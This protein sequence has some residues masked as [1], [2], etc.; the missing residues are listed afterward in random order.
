MKKL[1]F[2]LM[3]FVMA[4]SGC[5]ATKRSDV[6]QADSEMRIAQLERKVYEKDQQIEELQDQVQTLSSDKQRSSK[7]AAPRQETMKPAM[8]VV[9]NQSSQEQL[10]EQQKLLI[11]VD[12]SPQD[13]QTALKNAGY[14]DGNIDGKIGPRSQKAIMDFQADHN[15]KSDGIIG[16]QT[17]MELQS[18]LS[19]TASMAGESSAPVQE[20]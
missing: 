2:I 9:F 8:P 14:Y 17:W 5:I 16:K 6:V 18:Y 20:Q 15:L 11:R 4:L 7:S 19:P 13:V 3:G 12:V 1:F 10:Q